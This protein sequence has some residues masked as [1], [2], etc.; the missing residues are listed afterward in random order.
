M[1]AFAS[2][3]MNEIRE[4]FAHVD[5]CPFD[6]PRV[7]FENAGGALTLKSVAETSAAYAAYP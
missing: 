1:P 5:T 7:F 4:R 3:L 2:Q 6:G